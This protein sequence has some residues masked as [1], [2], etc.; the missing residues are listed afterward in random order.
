MTGLSLFFGLLA[1]HTWLAAENYVETVA[2]TGLAELNIQKGS[3]KD[4]NIADPF[5]VEFGPDGRMYV[6]EVGNHRVIAVDLKSGQAETIAG[7]GKK[8]YSGDGGLATKADLNE[9]YEVRF[10]SC[11]NIYFV[12]MINNI[13]RKIDAKTGV[14]QTIAGTGKK[15]YSG[16]GG[17]AIDATFNRPHSIVLDEQKQHLYV[18]DIGNHRIRRINLKT[19]MVDGFAGNGERKL[20]KHGSKVSP[21]VPMIGPRALYITNRTLW[22][23]LR[24]GHS[25]WKIDL[26]THVISQIAGTGKKGYSGD[27]GD[28]LKGT[29]NGPKGIVVDAKEE[30]IYVVDTEN[31]AIRRIDLVKN[32]L[33]SH[34]GYGPKGRGFI[35]NN[36]P[37]A[38]AK[39]GR[40]HGICIGPKGWVYTGDTL[41]HRVRRIIAK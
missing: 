7:T 2:G 28:P 3:V 4:F 22:V 32:R 9:P 27:G 41:N 35:G 30:N 20:P 23:A 21:D 8:G 34:A 11:G 29:F 5:G 38:K 26:D 40:P 18:A 19:G 39:F 13:I 14:I 10:D 16:D 1:V 15:G 37:S 6:T 12:E 31:Q 25:V 36:T 24:E 17:K 33:T